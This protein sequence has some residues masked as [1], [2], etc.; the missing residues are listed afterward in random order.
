MDGLLLVLVAD[1]LEAGLLGG[2]G[3][4]DG[5]LWCCGNGFTYIF[6]W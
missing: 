2:R 1:G 4:G 5:V 3:L 6:W